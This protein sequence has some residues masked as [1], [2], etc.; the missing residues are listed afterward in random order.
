[1]ELHVSDGRENTTAEVPVGE[2]EH[3]SVAEM[4]MATLPEEQQVVLDLEA[5]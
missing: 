3:G 4:L 5:G 2:P 1:M